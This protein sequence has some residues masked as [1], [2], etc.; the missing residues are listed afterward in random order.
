VRGLLTDS[1]RLAFQIRG[2]GTGASA[3]SVWRD[4]S[5]QTFITLYIRAR[6]WFLWAEGDYLLIKSKLA[7]FFEIFYS[8]DVVE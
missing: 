7:E 8:M 3:D 6:N 5:D 1:A 4:N 2:W